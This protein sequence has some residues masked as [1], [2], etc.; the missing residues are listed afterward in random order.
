[1]SPGR[2]RSKY[3]AY[4]S[5]R[6]VLSPG[7]VRIVANTELMAPKEAYISIFELYLMTI[8]DVLMT[9]GIL[10]CSTNFPLP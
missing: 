3:L 9:F 2:V 7:R 6:S 5:Q 1:M 8:N 4:G 10:P